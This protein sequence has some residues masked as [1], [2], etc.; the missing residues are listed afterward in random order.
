CLI[1]KSHIQNLGMSLDI[2]QCQTLAHIDN[3]A[4]QSKVTFLQSHIYDLG[5]GICSTAVDNLL[6][7]HSLGPTT[8]HSLHHH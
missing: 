1:P 5:D 6:K 8:V 4:W 7:E 2:K 3:D